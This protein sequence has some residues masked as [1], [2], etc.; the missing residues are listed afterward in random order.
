MNVVVTGGG[1]IAPIDDVRLMTNVSSG[2]FAAAITEA[3][4]EKG[5]TV[6]HIHSLSA[7]LPIW[8]F[9]QFALDASDP[10]AELLR[11]ARLRQKWLSARDRLQLVPLRIGTVADYATTLEQVLHSQPIDVVVLPMAVA[12]FE[13]AP[14]ARQDQLRHRNPDRRV[15]PH[16]QG[17]PLDSRLVSLGLPGRFQAPVARRSA[18]ADPP[19][20]RS[21][22]KPTGPT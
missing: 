20:R 8:R 18:R 6:A 15:P 19:P 21:P 3:F 13:P 14:H 1:T 16:R 10:P 7:Q 9:A 5:A 22:A 11:L 17:D 4:L 2:R 12:D